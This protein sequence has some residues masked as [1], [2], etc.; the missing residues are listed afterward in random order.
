VVLAGYHEPSLIFMLGRETRLAANGA[1][2]AAIL[3]SEGARSALVDEPMLPAF[4]ASLQE[5]GYRVVAW[6]GV[7]GFNYSRGDHVDLSLLTIEAMST[8]DQVG[9]SDEP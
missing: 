9:E 3:S 4:E 7:Q 1:E 5:R 8:S 6:G 2:A